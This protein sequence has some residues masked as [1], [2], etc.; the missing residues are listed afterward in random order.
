MPKIVDTLRQVMT[1]PTGF[2]ADGRAIGV[3]LATALAAQRSRV[4]D[5]IDRHLRRWSEDE[6]LDVRG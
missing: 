3:G 6:R 5:D 2:N 4:V 1:Q